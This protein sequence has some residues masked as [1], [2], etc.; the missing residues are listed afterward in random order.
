[1]SKRRS[2]VQPASVPAPFDPTPPD[3]PATIDLNSPPDPERH[4]R[5]CSI[6]NHPHRDSIEYDFIH[7]VRPH[8]IVCEYQLYDHKT[9]YRHVQ[10]LGLDVL[11]RRNLRVALEPILEHAYCV[12]IT[13]AAIVS[14]ARVYSHINDD[15]Q[16]EEPPRESVV[17]KVPYYTE[18]LPPRLAERYK[19]AHA[20]QQAEIEAQ[21]ATNPIVSQIRRSV[22]PTAVSESNLE[23]PT[24]NFQN[25]I[26][27]NRKLESDVSPT[28]QTTAPVSNRPYPRIKKVLLRAKTRPRGGQR[29]PENCEKMDALRG[30][31]KKQ[32][33]RH[34][35]ERS[36]E[37]SLFLRGKT[38]RA[39]PD[40]SFRAESSARTRVRNNADSAVFRSPLPAMRK[41]T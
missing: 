7:W 25:L 4:S 30:C 35:E 14:A 15:G 29:A 19:R 32:K 20:A 26:D 1:M 41:E 27:H 40:R 10:A 18:G 28:K 36:D 5:K 16:W 11:R 8:S 31:G 6:C 37:E 33:R 21:A 3:E 9:L 38:A 39:I 22:S 12:R 13:A 17:T 34:S 24:S 2:S 23:P